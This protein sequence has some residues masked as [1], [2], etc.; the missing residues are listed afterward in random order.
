MKLKTRFFSAATAALVLSVSLAGCSLGGGAASAE[1]TPIPLPSGVPEDL[2]QEVA[3]MPKDT[4]LLTVDGKDV[5]AEDV[6]YWLTYTADQYSMYGMMDWTQ[7]VGDQTMA[8]YLLDNAVQTAT[9][10][11][12]VR[13]HADELKMGWSKANQSDYDSRL[14]EILSNL[15]SQISTQSGST[16]ASASPSVSPS[17][18]PSVDPEVSAKADAQ[19]I[20]SLAYMGLSQDGF[21]RINQV[22]YFYDN[23][24]TGLYGEDGSEAPTPERLDEAK[25]YH[26]KHILI[27]AVASADGSDDGMATALEK[28]N[29][30][31]DQ[32]VQ[33]DDPTSTFDQLRKENSE[34]VDSSGNLNDGEDGY[35]FG[36]GEMVSEFE[37]G[38]AALKIGEISKPVKSQYGYHIILRLDADNDA[39]HQK[40]ADVKIQDQIDQWQKAAKVE[41]TQDLENL[42]GQSFYEKLGELRTTMSAAADAENGTAPESPSASPE[43]SPSESATAEPSASAAS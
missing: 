25:V 18:S 23:L 7:K 29:T 13:N 28:A 30:L 8:E 9:L 19:F 2:I 31:Y 16:D 4:V 34:D 20:R 5:V 33:S 22:S 42:D 43:A 14:D 12:V 40:Y 27:K 6:L 21:Y 32:I 3:G 38:T 35:T 41:K 39:G 37:D 10:Y 36:P 17:A 11:Q 24:K 26:V 1:P 15:A